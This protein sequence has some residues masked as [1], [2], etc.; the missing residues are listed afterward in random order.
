M[1]N[2]CFLMHVYDEFAAAERLVKQIRILY[3]RIELLVLL[4]GT[5]PPYEFSESWIWDRYTYLF[6]LVRLKEVQYG[7]QWTHRYL[8]FFLHMTSVERCIKLDPDSWL[9]RS[10]H[11]FP[12]GDIFGEVKAVNY[13]GQPHV[14]G[15][16]IGFTRH[17]ATALIKHLLNP[18]YKT[19]EFAYSRPATGEIISLQD[20]IVGDAAQKAGL[21]LAPWSEVRIGWDE[22]PI[23]NP[24][25][26]YAIT[27]PYKE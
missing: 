27:H 19:D 21:K 12:K 23:A 24:D 10:L 9:W 4:D 11:H 16:A 17:G 20:A 14:R 26:K 7:G 2:F 25:L 5:K 13:R 8:Q 18:A 3:P 15:G 22:P 1:Q 6:K